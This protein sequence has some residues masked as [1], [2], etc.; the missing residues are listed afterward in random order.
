MK[1]HFRLYVEVLSNGGPCDQSRKMVI[2]TAAPR[3][4]I[5]C[6]PCTH[7]QSS[8]FA[9]FHEFKG[10]AFLYNDSLKGRAKVTLRHSSGATRQYHDARLS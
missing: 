2:A 4:P 6:S 5:V 10:F 9:R 1:F 8:E 3:M 7:R